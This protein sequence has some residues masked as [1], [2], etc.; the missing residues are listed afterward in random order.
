QSGSSM[1]LTIISSASNVH[2]R[3]S[4]CS[5]SFIRLIL[6]SSSRNEKTAD[7]QMQLLLRPELP[8]TKIS[9]GLELMQLHA[10]CIESC[11][12]E[13]DHTFLSPFS[14]SIDLSTSFSF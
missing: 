1:Y 10:E 9:C 14:K 3:A 7:Q 8:L 11:I 6:L 4:L 13:L 5:C 2:L 12:G